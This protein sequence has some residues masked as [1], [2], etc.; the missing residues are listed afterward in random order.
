MSVWKDKRTG[1][2]RVKFMWQGKFQEKKGIKTR[3]KA[4]RW[5]VQRR[6]EL[7]NPPPIKPASSVSIDSL[8]I[9]YLENCQP[10]MQANTVRSKSLYYAAFLG[11]LPAY[12]MPVDQI[13]RL[14]VT[15]YI[16]KVQ[17]GSVRIEEVATK[18]RRDYRK[19]ANRHLRDL[20]ALFNWAVA[21]DLL[22]TSPA[23]GIQPFPEDPY[24]KYVPPAED[25][26]KVLLVANRQ[27]MD[28]L[29]VLYHAAARIGEIRRLT[30]EDVNFEKKWVR[31]WTRKRK[32]GQLEPDLL[33]MTD[34]LVD[35]LSRRW[36]TRVKTSPYVF[37]NPNTGK[38]YTKDTHALR[39]LMARL[40][41][42]AEVK[43][44]TFHAIRHHVASIINDSGKA[45]LTQIQKYLR[46]RRPTTTENYL[47]EVGRSLREVADILGSKKVTT[48][49]SQNRSGQG[50]TRD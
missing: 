18:R 21:N 37:V 3:E 6:N 36:K 8:I 47:H 1:K 28:L 49:P 25:I 45:T 40:C 11:A 10:R 38:P 27:E 22:R 23:R 32:G 41:R 50:E 43:Q 16:R 39:Y 14:Q 4:I 7:E 5:E 31:L 35:V 2:Y 48:P 30:W 42:R 44:F 46:H 33:P 24:I 9:K 17:D 15:E 20:K 13:T 29:L 26:D 34:I 12:D 19:T